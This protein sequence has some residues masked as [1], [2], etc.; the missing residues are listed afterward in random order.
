[1][2]PRNLPSFFFVILLAGLFTGCGSR[3]SASADKPPTEQEVIDAISKARADSWTGS[4]AWPT[5]RVETKV[6]GIQFGGKVQKQVGYGEPAREV[7]AVKAK[8]ASKVYL[9]NGTVKDDVQE[10]KSGEAYFFYRDAFGAWAFK[11]GSL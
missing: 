2:N 6:T 10:M 9:K 8:A 5:D 4:A 7:W 3:T 1:M 11:W